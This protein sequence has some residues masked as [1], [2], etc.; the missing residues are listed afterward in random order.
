MKILLL[1]NYREDKQKSMIRFGNLLASGVPNYG[2]KVTEVFP[3]SKIQK[4][5]FGSKLRKL[6]GYIDKYIIFKKKIDSILKKTK[7]DLIH[8]SDHSNSI[9]LPQ[10]IRFSQIPKLTTCH[11]LIAIRSASGEFPKAPITSYKGK[12]L[13]RYIEKSLSY[14]D[15]FACDSLQT[16]FDLNKRIPQ[17]RKRSKVIHLGVEKLNSKNFIH[18][19]K[20]GFDLGGTDYLLHIGSDSWYK[21]RK[22]VLEAFKF[23]FKSKKNHFQKLVFVGPTLKPHELNPELDSWIKKNND[24]LIFIPNISE[25]ELQSLYKHASLFIF[26]S[27]IEGFG[28]PPMEAY[29][30]TC[31]S[32]TTKTGAIFEILKDRVIYVNPN[33]Q[34]DLNNAI[35][36]NLRNDIQFTNFLPTNEECSKNYAMLYRRI[37][38]RGI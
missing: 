29:A 20:L 27:F 1:S 30:N 28:W 38:K 34:S 25:N 35:I 2:A 23:S 4:F 5:C 15:Y 6:S 19:K 13:Q 16:K 32:V 26:P 37:I 24:K 3:K 17:S 7:F 10:L 31:P 8:I 21:N 12:Q 14:S 36:H 18:N 22:G 33:N 11:D 9:Y